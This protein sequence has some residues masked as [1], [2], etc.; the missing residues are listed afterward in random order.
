M[1]QDFVDGNNGYFGLSAR[2][3]KMTNRVA[4]GELYPTE[5]IGV[6]QTRQLKIKL[7]T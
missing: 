3:R 2:K 5:D 4:L 7:L 1:Q 6:F